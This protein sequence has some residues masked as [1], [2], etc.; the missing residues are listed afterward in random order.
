[1][2]VWLGSQH[3]LSGFEYSSGKCAAEILLVLRDSRILRS[4]LA[5][6][7]SRTGHRRESENKD[8][9]DPTE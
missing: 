3:N 4:L 1:M 5:P 7:P 2:C 9:T 6:S 8:D